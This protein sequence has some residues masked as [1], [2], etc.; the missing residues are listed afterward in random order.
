VMSGKN[1][2]GFIEYYFNG[3]GQKNSD[4][5]LAGLASNPE[6]LKRLARGELF[7]LGRHYLGASITL[8]L[9]P[10]L[11]ITPNFF[12]N[13]IDPSALAQLVVAYDWKQDI[14]LLGALNLPIGPSG[15][16]YGGINSPQPGLYV[17]T[18]ASLFVQFAW[19]F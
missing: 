8:E 18:G 15:S 17:S 13:L 2:T 4:Y 6:L 9:H 14:Q 19:Y 5:T 3:F 7:N 12:I 11:N 10:L 16:E 1:W